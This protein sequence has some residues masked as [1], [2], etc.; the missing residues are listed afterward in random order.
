MSPLFSVLT[1]FWI[2]YS[3]TKHNIYV[4]YLLHMFQSVTLIQIWLIC[5]MI[6][7][8]AKHKVRVH[9]YFS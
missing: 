1:H 9:V 7:M 4:K 6:E 3:N 8:T 5:H 2:F